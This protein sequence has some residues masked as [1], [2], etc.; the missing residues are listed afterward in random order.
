MSAEET[1]KNE[2]TRLCRVS[3]MLCTGHAALRDR[4]A[5]LAF[6]LDLLTLGVSTWLV[7]LAFVEPKLNVRFNTLRVGQPSLGWGAWHWRLLPDA[8]SNETTGKVDQ[9]HI[10]GPWMFMPKLSVKRAICC[11]RASTIMIPASASSLD[12]T[13]QP[14]SASQFPNQSF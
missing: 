12:M 5:K 11:R 2:L 1:L 13:W 8:D 14:L 6:A 4:Y 3:D 10:K 7:A 9:T